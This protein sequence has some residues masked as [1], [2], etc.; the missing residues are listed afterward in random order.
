MT[1]IQVT[2]FLYQTDQKSRKDSS[3]KS[4]M[5]VSSNFKEKK[6]LSQTLRYTAE[7][8]K[9]IRGATELLNKQN[10]VT[11]KLIFLGLMIALGIYSI[12]TSRSKNHFREKVQK[13]QTEQ[14]HLIK[15]RVKRE[16]RTKR[17]LQQFF[18]LVRIPFP[19]EEEF[20]VSQSMK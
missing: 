5:T 13:H 9:E 15:S 11:K 14:L 12:S 10:N 4:V 19:D 20:N 1:G 2:E 18:M 6:I 8:P 17:M 3:E 7:G 16:T